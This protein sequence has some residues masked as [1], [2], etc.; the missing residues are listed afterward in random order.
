MNN[1]PSQLTIDLAAV[2]G[3][4]V[5]NRTACSNAISQAKQVL[6]IDR[7][8]KSLTADDKAA[9]IQWHKDRLTDI[10]QFDIETIAPAVALRTDNAIIEEVETIP[11]PRP[12]H[13]DTTIIPV[14]INNVNIETA[15]AAIADDTSA[16]IVEKELELI[17]SPLSELELLRIENA[18][19]QARLDKV[20]HKNAPDYDFNETVRIAFYIGDKRTVIALSGFYL[21]AL[22]LAAGIDKK[23]VPKW[24]KTAVD[25]WGAFDDKLN[26]T[27]QVKL[28]IVRELEKAYK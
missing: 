25:S 18:K 9:I 12:L 26:V 27:E 10:N 22:M 4:A 13:I 16:P 14:R 11:A 20:D 1:E 7:H 24:I 3:F 19:L 23:G 8:T 15:P 6:G 5:G 17:N 28:L 21:N 2:C